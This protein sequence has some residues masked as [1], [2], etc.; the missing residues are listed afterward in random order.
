MDETMMSMADF[1]NPLPLRPILPFPVDAPAHPFQPIAPAPPRPANS[2]AEL[3]APTD[4]LAADTRIRCNFEGCTKTFGRPGDQ[5]RHM[6]KHRPMKYKCIDVDC[7]MKFYRIDKLRDHLRQ[8]HGI[9]NVL[10][11]R[12]LARNG[13]NL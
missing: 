10:S 13:N 1:G 8:G 6:R 5:H 3:G 12:K 9:T 7:D 4:I 2:H 11:P